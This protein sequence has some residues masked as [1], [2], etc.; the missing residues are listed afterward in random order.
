MNPGPARRA[1][2]AIIAWPRA[3]RGRIVDLSIVARKEP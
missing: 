2:R 1:V 3:P